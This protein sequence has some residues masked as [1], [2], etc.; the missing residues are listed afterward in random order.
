MD[1]V[2]LESAVSRQ[3]SEILYVS[4]PSFYYK[5]WFIVYV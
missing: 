1:Q 5:D 3:T 2:I 4:V